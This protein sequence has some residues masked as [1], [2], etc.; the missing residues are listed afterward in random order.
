MQLFANLVSCFQYQLEDGT[1]NLDKI[2]ERISQKYA[3]ATYAS[4]WNEIKAKCSKV[5]T[6][7]RCELANDLSMCIAVEV[8]K[9][10]LD[11]RTY[12]V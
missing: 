12:F 9:K 4:V 2:A 8:L 10:G 11:P 6:D 3:E 7:D 1:T 5:K